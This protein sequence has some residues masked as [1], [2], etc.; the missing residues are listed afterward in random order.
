MP[1]KLAADV[2]AL[3]ESGA[4]EFHAKMI[5]KGKEFAVFIRQGKIELTTIH[6]QQHMQLCHTIQFY[7]NANM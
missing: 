2:F 6:E 1:C 3:S 7:F 4:C 5:I